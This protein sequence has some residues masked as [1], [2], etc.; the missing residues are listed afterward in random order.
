MQKRLKK[1][2]THHIL[3]V[4]KSTS[5]IHNFRNTLKEK[6][7]RL[8]KVTNLKKAISHLKTNNVDLIVVDKIF[9]Q[10]TN[11]FKKFTACANF[12]PKLIITHDHNY[13]GLR[14]LLNDKFTIPLQEP[15]S[16]G[17][18]EYLAKLLMDKDLMR[19]E[20]AQ[21]HALL[22][23]KKRELSFFEDITKILTST[24]KLNK[25]ISAIIKKTKK[26]IGAEAGTILLIDKEKGELFFEK[27]KKKKSKTGKKSR[28][29]VGEGI[30]GWVAREGVPIIIPDISKDPKFKKKAD[31]LLHPKPKSLICI[32]IKIKDKV[33]GVLEVVNKITGDT[34][35]NSDLDLLLKLV[36][37]AA[38]AIERASLYQKME[39]LTITDDLTSL[40]NTRY[41]NHAIEMEIDR[42]SRYGFALTLIFMDVDFFKKI[43][44]K[45]GHLV[46]GKLLSEI[47]QLLTRNVRTI[48]IV[49]RYGGD[50]FV[51]VLPQTSMSF[52]FQVAE[53]LRK[54]IENHV[55]LKNKGFSFKITASFGVAAYPENAKSKEELLHIADKAMYR[56]KFSTRNVV[57]AA[58]K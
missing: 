48:D 39:E 23:G 31:T 41:L 2:N 17:E 36:N 51:L 24:L 20:N 22:R 16:L 45:H 9:S 8:T 26:M 54:K 1:E 35:T 12:I 57:Y 40:F 58:T 21:L 32:P 27:A 4:E 29:K 50:E 14:T 38:M 37:H 5:S 33:I 47:A 55:F 15:I 56:G 7:F 28:I 6:Q 3:L 42:S 53:R 43:N 11:D 19:K 52:G 49:A 30:A 46:G 10:S 34:F 13:K 44:D 18:F 25:I